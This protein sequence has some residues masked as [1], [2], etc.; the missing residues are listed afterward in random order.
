MPSKSQRF[1]LWT[2]QEEETLIQALDRV[3]GPMWSQILVRHG[4]NGTENDILKHRS[5][6]AIAHRASLLYQARGVVA[7]KFLRRTNYHTGDHEEGDHEASQHGRSDHEVFGRGSNQEQGVVE[8]GSGGAFPAASNNLG[9]VAEDEEVDSIM[10]I[11]IAAPIRPNDMLENLLK[12][13]KPVTEVVDT[14]DDTEDSE[15][16]ET[17]LKRRCRM[18]ELKRK[19]ALLEKEEM[20][21]SQKK[22]KT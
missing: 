19:L 15:D 8:Q 13:K 7:P 18:Q 3:Q 17:A 9:A 10:G 11:N 16:E 22:T 21:R 4:V 6:G 1:R 12:S 5:A 20:S 14:V 2:V